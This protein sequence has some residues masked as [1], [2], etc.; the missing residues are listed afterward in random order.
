MQAAHLRKGP[1]DI[2]PALSQR[3]WYYGCKLLL[4]VTPQGICTGFVLAPANTEDRWVAESFVCWRHDLY[5]APVS[6]EETLD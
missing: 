3:A 1:R 4:S 5:Q 2:D 6:P